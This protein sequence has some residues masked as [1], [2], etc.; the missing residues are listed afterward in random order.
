MNTTLKSLTLYERIRLVED[1]WDSIALDHK[2]IPLAQDQMA[3]LDGRLQ[4]FELDGN[5]G[6]PAAEVIASIRS[7]L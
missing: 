1:L 4:A 3:E 7:R 5:P 2:A 6:R